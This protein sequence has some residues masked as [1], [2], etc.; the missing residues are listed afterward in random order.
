M[1][2]EY[3]YAPPPAAP[4]SSGMAI[5]S[6]IA[7]ILGLT[8]LPTIGSIVGLILGY[9]A[10]NQI[11]DS[12]GTMGG[13]GLAKAGIIVGWIGIGFTLIACCIVVLAFA[14]GLGIP[15]IAICSEMGNMY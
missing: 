9:M 13:E 3:S 7:S 6:L 11:Q 4:P 10:R 8:L 15:G 12:G 2:Q 5:A 14:L 1:S